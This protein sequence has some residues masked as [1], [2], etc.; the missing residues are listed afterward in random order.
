[1]I[2]HID[3]RGVVCLTLNRPARHNAL[4]A[5]LISA[6]GKHIDRLRKHPG[7]HTLVLTGAGSS[8]CSGA[9]LHWLGQAHGDEEAGRGLRPFATLLR[10]LHELPLATI[11]RVNGP[12]YGGGLGLIACCDFAIAVEQ[13]RFAFTELRL[14]LVPAMIAPYVI[15]RTGGHQARQYFLRAERFD[16][17]QA[18]DSGL[19][20][21]VCAAGQLDTAVETLLQSLLQAGPEALAE[22]K[23]LLSQI[24]PVSADV[25]QQATKTSARVAASAE[26]REGIRA[27]LQKSRPD[28]A[29]N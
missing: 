7:L 29:P 5:A 3:A 22:C 17:R 27:F 13:A 24:C 10:Q 18:R 21:E 15:A 9:D 19:I 2:E 4:D 1:V 23:R 16:A 6:L 11:A 28:W 25:T 14:G 26:A 8:F 20:D 12:A